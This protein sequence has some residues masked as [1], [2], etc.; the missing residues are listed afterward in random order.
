MKT[1][2]LALF[3]SLT[4]AFSAF[5]ETEK[6]TDKYK[7]VDSTLLAYYRWCNAHIRD[8]VVMLK[9]DTMFHIAQ[10]RKNPRMQSVALSIKADHYYF[11]N[12]LDSL[13]AWIP[14]VQNFAREHNQLTYYYFTWSRLIFYYTKH[15]QFTLAQYELERY[16]A[17][18]EKDDY[19]PAMADAYKEMGHIFHARG[20]SGQAADSYRKA[21]DYIETN[22]LDKFFLSNLYGELA[23][24][25][26]NLKEFTE[27]AEAIEKGIQ[28]IPL[29]EHIWGLK[30]KQIQLYTQTGRIEEARRLY[31][32]VE[33]G[34]GQRIKPEQLLDIKLLIDIAAKDF[35]RAY[36]TA[37]K[38]VEV[39]KKNGSAEYSYTS[40]FSKL[41]WICCGLGDYKA[42]YEYQTHYI[43][44]YHEKITNDQ[45][46]T[47]NEFATLLDV[48]RLDKE[49]AEAEQLA[50]AERLRRTR[51]VIIALT[52]ILLLSSAFIIVLTRMN[53]RLAHAKRAAE[54]ANRMKGVFIRNITHEINTPLNAIVGFAGLA[55]TEQADAVE[56]QD[57]INIIQENSGYLQKLI[58]DVL[59]ISDIESAE[60]APS[61]APTD[62]NACCLKCLRK[63]SENDPHQTVIRFLPDREAYT[64]TTSSLLLNK[65]LTELLSNAVRFAPGGSVTLAYTV[66]G[67]SVTFT[68][69]DSGP[70][71][72]AAEAEHIFERFVKLDTFSQG[73]GLGLS[74]A[75]LIARTLGGELR[76][77]TSYTSGTRFVM[78]I[79]VR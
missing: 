8:S 19:K 58:D 59:Y 40:I 9:T 32:E 27:A 29:P 56:R 21:I 38:L 57:Y 72:P 49:R 36:D 22:D 30:L 24:E 3:L 16:L 78:R 10:A 52:V 31:R 4:T 13:K 77:D 20:L 53:R 17:Q 42:A 34:N 6:N 64:A 68:V 61:T 28:N 18:A 47:L 1:V 44:L 54:E 7:D 26:I 60:S 15:K 62:I 69:T 67:G 46:Q 33:Q 43:T 14:R 71:I 39:H 11:T 35:R 74:V 50:Q 79:S 63:V 2:L 25:L 65:A 76:L 70:G 48:N 5:A 37:E 41:A 12:Q 23:S 45:E 55:A 51:V 66:G 75:R 73:L